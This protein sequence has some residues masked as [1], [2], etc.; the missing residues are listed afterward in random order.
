MKKIQFDQLDSI[1]GGT[2][3]SGTIINAFT[4]VIRVLQ[5]AGHSLG[6]ALRRIGE[7]NLCPLE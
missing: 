6:S 3:I 4:N 1:Y 7:G 5:E 2:T